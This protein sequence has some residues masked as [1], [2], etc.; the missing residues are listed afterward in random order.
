[1]ATAAFMAPGAFKAIE[2]SFHSSKSIHGSTSNAG[3]QRNSWQH[4]QSRP[5]AFMAT[6]A[7]KAI[8]SSFIAA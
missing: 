7:F 5:A 2:M 6:G 4:E 3:L 8:E 1:M